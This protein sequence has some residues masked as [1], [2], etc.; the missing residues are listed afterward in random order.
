MNYLSIVLLLVICARPACA[1]DTAVALAIEWKAKLIHPLPAAASM[2]APH[3]DGGISPEATAAVAVGVSDCE[4]ESHQL[5]GPWES[6]GKAWAAA[7]GEAVFRVT[8]D[9]PG[10]LVD[11]DLEMNLGAIDDF[12]TTF[13]N[14]E[15]VGHT[16]KSVLGHWAVQ[17]VYRVPARLAKAGKL[18][19]AVRVFDHFG[20]GG[21]TGPKEHMLL[22]LAAP[23]APAASGSK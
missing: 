7:D 22:R 6:Y 5:P 18:L 23:P 14:G 12:D 10:A 2:E 11:H 20:G 8:I 9:L 13:V 21:F 4:W 3:T 19:I 1:E 16:D 17:R 15:A